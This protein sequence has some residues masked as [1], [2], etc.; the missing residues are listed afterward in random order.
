[1]SDSNDDGVEDENIEKIREESLEMGDRGA[2]APPEGQKCARCDRDAVRGPGK[3]WFCD[4][5]QREFFAERH[6]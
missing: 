3:E 2:L 5:H 6:G 1:M 4:E